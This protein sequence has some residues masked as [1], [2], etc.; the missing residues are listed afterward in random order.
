[1]NRHGFWRYQFPPIGWAIVIFAISSLPG[2]VIPFSTPFQLDKLFHAGIFFV[3]CFLLNR[4]LFSQS[5]FPSLSRYHLVISLLIVIAYGVSDEL[6][7]IF[8]PG[9]DP[10]IYDALADSLGGL[11]CTLYLLLRKSRGDNRGDSSQNTGSQSP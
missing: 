8:V 6:H 9:R 3:L 5:H 1:M 2:S 10:D 11:A 7:Q 4:A